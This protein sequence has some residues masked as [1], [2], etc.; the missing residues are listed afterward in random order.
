[1]SI[2]MLHPTAS[3]MFFITDQDLP[4]IC[5]K[6]HHEFMFGLHLIVE[7]NFKISFEHFYTTIFIHSIV[8]V[9]AIIEKK[10]EKHVKVS[11]TRRR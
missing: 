3:R 8:L 1:M 10:L 7:K 2:C 11:A 6:E 4:K 9:S 5:K